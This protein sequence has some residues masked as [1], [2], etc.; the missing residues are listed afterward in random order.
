MFRG[1]GIVWLAALCGCNAIFGVSD[2]EIG[3]ANVGGSAQGGSPATGGNGGSPGVGGAP[4]T[5]GQP[6]GGGGNAAGG[7]NTGGGGKGAGGDGG[8][9]GSG[10][11]PPVLVDRGLVVRYFIDEAATGTGPQAVR[12]SGPAPALDLTLSYDNMQYV[13]A[14][15]GRGIELSG[16]HDGYAAAPTP[17][18]T[19]IRDVFDGALESTMEIVLDVAGDN[20]LGYP[21]FLQQDGDLDGRFGLG[22]D[23]D[24]PYFEYNQDSPGLQDV[25][26]LWD[27]NLKAAGR[28]VA[29]V[30]VDTT[31]PNE[32]DR[33]TFFVN[34]VQ[35]GNQTPN[36]AL[37]PPAQNEGVD[38]C[39]N[40]SLIIGNRLAGTHPFR[41]VVYYAA[42]YNVALTA[43]ERQN[44]VDLLM[45]ND[46]TPP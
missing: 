46:D 35:A 38:T 23:G 18:G 32:E 11:S 36:V 40:C 3:D 33:I 2:K 26:A 1:A 17:D 34:G 19:K 29:H 8:M 30:I 9:G 27:P 6:Q 4:G 21:F 43:N 37:I 12:D 20:A 13:Q 22:I 31:L 24:T 14:S 15:T 44:N 42:I 10:G 16:N 5:G 25:S 39:A 41:G 28:V 45:V 7:D